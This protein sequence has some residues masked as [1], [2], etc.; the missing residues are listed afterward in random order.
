MLKVW[1][2]KKTLLIMITSLIMCKT[3]AQYKETVTPVIDRQFGLIKE[4]HSKGGE[5]KGSSYLNEDWITSIVYLK[6]GHF[7]IDKFEGI[8]IKAN[9]QSNGIEIETEAG[10]KLIESSIFDKFEWTNPQTNE[11]EEYVNCNKFSVG[12]TRLDGFCRISGDKIRLVSRNYVEIIKSNYNVAMDVGSK[13]DEII[14]KSKCYLLTD[15][16]LIE[17]KNKQTLYSTMA[18]K[19]AEIKTFIQVNKIR[20]SDEA[21]LRSVVTYYNKISM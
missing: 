16:V 20:L 14:K 7:S 21:D 3:S 6:P 13:E 12:G 19:A 2:M 10:I 18:D 8:R 11:K 15:D 5:V 1:D 4:L 17:C 9:L